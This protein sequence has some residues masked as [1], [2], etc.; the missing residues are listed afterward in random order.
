M[1]YK[2]EQGRRKE[3]EASVLCMLWDD[4]PHRM[5]RRRERTMQHSFMSHFWSLEHGGDLILCVCGSFDTDR[6]LIWAM[7]L[8]QFLLLSTVRAMNM[9]SHRLKGQRNVP[10]DTKSHERGFAVMLIFQIE[11][12]A[13]LWV[14]KYCEVYAKKAVGLRHFSIA[15]W[16]LQPEKKHPHCDSTVCETWEGFWRGALAHP[17]CTVPRLQES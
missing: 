13:S 8:V 14:L 12:P 3:E 1:M 4:L 16:S 11:L 10:W 2:R 17:V 15:A 9:Q 6:R 5:W 7:T